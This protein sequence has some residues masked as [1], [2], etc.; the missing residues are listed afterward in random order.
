MAVT[1]SGRFRPLSGRGQLTIVTMATVTCVLLQV[2][3]DDQR[4]KLINW[5]DKYQGGTWSLGLALALRI[6]PSLDT[7][8]AKDSPTTDWRLTSGL[9]ALQTSWCLI[10]RPWLWVGWREPLWTT[11]WLSVDLDKRCQYYSPIPLK[12]TIRTMSVVLNWNNRCLPL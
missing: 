11:S 4:K 8:T 7:S 12:A 9:F 10:I 1:A 5:C 6:Q 2:C 3:K